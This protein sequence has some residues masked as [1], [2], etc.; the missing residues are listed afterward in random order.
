MPAAGCFLLLLLLLL[1]QFR[2]LLFF[3][4]CVAVCDVADGVAAAVAAVVGVPA[5]CAQ[6]RR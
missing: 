6:G 3:Y 4:V 5:A 2:A 1:L